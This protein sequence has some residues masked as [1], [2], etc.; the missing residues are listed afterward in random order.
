MPLFVRISATD[1]FD[2]MTDEFPESWTVV[3]SVKI[4]PILASRGVDLLDAS[5]GGIHPL[6]KTSIKSGP[7]YQAPFALEIKKADGD[8]M[9]VSAVGGIRIAELDQQLTDD[10]LDVIM[11][12]CWSQKNP[13]LVY[14]FA[15]D[16]EVDVKRANQ[17][18]WGFKGQTKKQST[19]QVA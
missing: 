12:G 15:D 4:A 9:T 2:N 14:S 18:A 17:I 11:C 8:K 16:L 3:D 1:W 10:G 19:K 13:G 7:G 6:Q 5:S